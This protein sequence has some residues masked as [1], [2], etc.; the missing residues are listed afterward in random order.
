MSEPIVVPFAKSAR[1]RNASGQRA[2]AS[3]S[4]RSPKS[5]GSASPTR[6]ISYRHTARWAICSSAPNW[7]YTLSQ[8][9]RARVHHQPASRLSARGV[10]SLLEA[11]ER[12]G[13][14]STSASR[15]KRTFCICMSPIRSAPRMKEHR[16]IAARSPRASARRS[17]PISRRRNGSPVCPRSFPHPRRRSPIRTK[18]C[19]GAEHRERG[20]PSTTASTS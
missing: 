12:T 3:A 18:S 10:R 13:R 7:K 16:E 15:T 17:S 11:A 19:R 5:L 9:A 4:L 2:G 1:V 14:S 8:A 6:T 20:S